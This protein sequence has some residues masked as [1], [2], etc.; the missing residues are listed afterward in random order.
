[1]FEIPGFNIDGLSDDQLM[2]KSN[3]LHRKVAWA[4]RFTQNGGIE[5]LNKMIE[6]INIKRREM[7]FMETWRASAGYLSEP[8]ES[9]PEL[10]EKDHENDPAPEKTQKS[11]RIR[12]TMIRRTVTVPTTHPVVPETGEPS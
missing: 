8:I 3:E 9:D 2:E 6:L 10:R 7:M 11:T 12:P 5:M 1:M 4:S